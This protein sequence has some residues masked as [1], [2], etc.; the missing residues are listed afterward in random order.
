MFLSIVVSKAVSRMI[1]RPESGFP[2]GF[3]MGNEGLFISQLQLTDIMI[4][5]EIEVPQLGVLR[6][7]LRCFETVSCLS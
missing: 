2:R 7:F 3:V 5:F 1:K 6:C 4:L